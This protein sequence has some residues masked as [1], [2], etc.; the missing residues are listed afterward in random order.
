MRTSSIEVGICA[1]SARA[2]LKILLILVSF[3]ENG[4]ATTLVIVG[5]PR[6]IVV[7]ADSMSDKVTNNGRTVKATCKIVSAGKFVYASAGFTE[8]VKF[9]ADKI[10]ERSARR[11]G[12]IAEHVKWYAK[13]AQQP[14]LE[15]MKRFH[16]SLPEMYKRTVSSNGSTL[17]TIFAGIE[18]DRPAVALV[19]FMV[20]ND[21]SGKPKEAKT[22]IGA[23]PGLFCVDPKMDFWRVFGQNDAAI[24]A[25][26][27]TP[28]FWTG[29][30]AVDARKLVQIEIDAIPDRVGPPIDLVEID[31]T[32]LHWIE[33]RGSCV[34]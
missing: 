11:K 3:F 8:D 16:Q 15:M 25:V 23:C 6:H 2:W 28:R 31:S 7:A 20:I 4:T 33:P 29:N 9:N 32:G 30:D 14:F 24:Q 18:N 12:S 13:D 26:T 1:K 17:V 10:A 34:H 27:R 19:E 21:P 5:N 22:N